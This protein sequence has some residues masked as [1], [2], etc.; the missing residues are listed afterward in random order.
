MIDQDDLWFEFRHK[1]FLSGFE[2]GFGVESNALNSAGLL[3]VSA[4]DAFGESVGSS[5]IFF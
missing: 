1:L 2:R 3:L 5:Q 4:V